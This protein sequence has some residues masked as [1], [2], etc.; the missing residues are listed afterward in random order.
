M[1]SNPTIF[2][3]IVSSFRFQKGKVIIQDSMFKNKKRPIWAKCQLAAVDAVV[4]KFSVDKSSNELII[5]IYSGL[6]TIFHNE[7][8]PSTQELLK[9]RK[10]SKGSVCNS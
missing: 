1:G 6:S 5:P 3:D 8:K 2:C 4:D 10:G 9:V 7:D